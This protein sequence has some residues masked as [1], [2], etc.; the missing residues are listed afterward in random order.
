MSA[1]T[2]TAT[3]DV[4]SGHSAATEYTIDL[5]LIDIGHGKD[6]GKEELAS[7][8]GSPETTSWRNLKTWQVTTGAVR[9]NELLLLREFLESVSEGEQFDFDE[10]GSAGAPHNPISV[11]AVGTHIEQ[12]A[13]AQPGGGG[14]N[15][16]FRF[17]LSMRELP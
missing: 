12:R 9:A 14:S 5:R 2:Y 7:L 1:V 16:Y 8:D 4:T 3:R 15:D 13:I 6:V 10:F 11:V 17:S